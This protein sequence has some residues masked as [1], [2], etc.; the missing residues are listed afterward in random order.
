MSFVFFFCCC[1]SLLFLFPPAASKDEQ[2]HTSS[3][4]SERKKKKA[5]TCLITGGFAAPPL[6]NDPGSGAPRAPTRA[7]RLPM[8]IRVF[9]RWCPPAF[10]SLPP[11]QLPGVFP[12]PMLDSHAAKDAVET[13]QRVA[14]V[15]R[16]QARRCHRRWSLR[17][18]R[19]YVVQRKR[20]KWHPAQ[21]TLLLS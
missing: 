8:R 10:L 18:S 14:V 4:S 5:A 15:A 11:L 17:P 3:S 16:K 21:P 19:H 2:P 7:R 20:L 9:L 12:R 6:Q 1:C 13:Y